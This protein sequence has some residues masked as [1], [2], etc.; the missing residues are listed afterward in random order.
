MTQNFNVAK[1]QFSPFCTIQDALNVAQDGD[2]ITLNGTYDEAIHITKKI[3]IRGQNAVLTNRV[4][5]ENEV[6]IENVHFKQTVET[7]HAHSHFMSCTFDPLTGP[8]LITKGETVVLQCMIRNGSNGIE[9]YAPTTIQGTKIQHTTTGVL[10]ENTTITI[11]HSTILDSKTIGLSVIGG[12]VKLH[13]TNVLRSGQSNIK[14]DGTAASITDSAS[15]NSIDGAGLW[16]L[17]HSTV[18]ILNSALTNNAKPNVSASHTQLLIDQTKLERSKQCGIWLK[19]QSKAHVTNCVIRHNAFTNI[20]ISASMIQLSQCDIAHSAADGFHAS[21]R[22]IAHIDQ[23]NINDNVG[24]NVVYVN[25]E[26]SITNCTIHDAQ[27]NGIWLED[28]AHI[29]LKQSKLFRNAYP[30]V[31]LM[32]SKIDVDNCALFEG[33]QSGIWLKEQATARVRNSQFQ[34]QKGAH[35]IAERESTLS[36]MRCQLKHAGQN[37]V[38]ARSQSNVTV[39]DCKITH[40]AYPGI[41]GSQSTI[42]IV[43]STITHHR[44]HGVWLKEGTV[45]TIQTS[46]IA[47][48]GYCNIANEESDLTLCESDVTNAKEHGLLLKSNSH[49]FI[50]QSTIQQSGYD[51]VHVGEGAKLEMTDSTCRD[52]EHDGLYID[53]DSSVVVKNSHFIRNKQYGIYEKT[54][55]LNALIHHATFDENGQRDHLKQRAPKQ[56]TNETPKTTPPVTTDALAQ[57]D[58]LVGLHPLKTAMHAFV[59]LHQFEREADAFGFTEPM[60]VIAEHTVLTGNPGTGKTTVA[61]LIARLYNELGLLEKGHVVQ[62]NREQLVASYIGQ[63]AAKTQKKI[64]EAMGGVLFIDEAYALTQR[65]STNDFGHEAIEVLLEAMERYRGKFVVITAGY[66]EEMQRFLKSN[67]GLESRFSQLYHFDDYTP[68]DLLAIATQQFKTQQRQLTTS[69]REALY[70]RYISLWRQKD[71]FF[72]NARI[73]RHDV[74]TIINA[75]KLRCMSVARSKWSKTLLTTIKAEDIVTATTNKQKAA[76]TLPINEKLLQHTT[77][78]LKTLSGIDMVKNY[79]HQLI[80]LTNNMQTTAER[81]AAVATTVMI[82]GPNGTGKT[83][84]ARL[85][86]N[87]YIALGITPRHTIVE[88]TRDMLK[89]AFEGD[90]ERLIHRYVQQAHHGVLLIDDVHQ[91]AHGQPEKI[92]QLFHCLRAYQGEIIVLCT[93]QHMK[94]SL[95]LRQYPQFAYYFDET[96]TLR[97][98]TP[99]TLL[100][101]AQ[102][103]AQQVGYTI[104]AHATNALSFYFMHH[105]EYRD[106]NFSNV[107]LV[108]HTIKRAIRQAKHRQLKRN[109][110]DC[111][112]YVEDLQLR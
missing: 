67:P 23:C 55:T 102:H 51:N 95:L 76:V 38:W 49:T 108:T 93:G 5:I 17:N 52:A 72:A 60:P 99:T 1:E 89:S 94:L 85:L 57:L 27:K 64:D 112:I 3:I 30:A 34:H 65:D 87:V 88:I 18:S 6:H 78:T 63:T 24:S 36:L 4:Y 84:T 46:T 59:Q 68:D 97:D 2:M 35:I 10:A 21:K 103:Q 73:V 92:E 75:Q 20:D 53:T 31:A 98:Y 12:N 50:Q 61:H 15:K 48:N 40:C 28:H 106:D 71:R 26:G 14:L 54:N 32:H 9:A 11:E 81:A 43:H 33:A 105:Y 56:V 16:A 39:N 90:T 62:V 91:L 86:A 101:I 58:A 8:A 13:D 104:D 41:G 45:A 66:P 109:T 79:V 69:A 107:H 22:S 74:T 110:D 7:H 70:E 47:E 25:S 80:S 82:T 37:G 111:T 19:E 83:T 44:E 29:S 77:Q 96:I 42:D 100:K